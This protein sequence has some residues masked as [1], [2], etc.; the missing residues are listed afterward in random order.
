[1]SA[2]FLRR[3]LSKGVDMN[4]RCQK[5]RKFI[6]LA[7]DG[8]LERDAGKELA[9][10]L[11]GCPACHEWQQEQSWLLDLAGTPQ[12]LVPGH[13]FHARLMERIAAASRR[14][15][16]FDLSGVFFRP[17]LLRAAMVLLLVVSAATGFFLGAPLLDPA[18]DTRT[19][20]FNR[21]L[22]LDAFADLPADSF[23]AVYD[24]LLRG[25]IQ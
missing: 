8:R 23:G 3:G 10:H 24:R 6:S 7:M 11:G 20:A 13:D 16:V 14:S 25:E 21:T 19:A 18:P 9:A 15:P 22:N 5:A 12:V 4:M 2:S 17:A 1:M